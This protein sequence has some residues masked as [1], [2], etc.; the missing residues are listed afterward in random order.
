[1]PILHSSLLIRKS[2]WK[3][4]A[5]LSNLGVGL[6]VRVDDTSKSSFQCQE[7]IW[8]DLKKSMN[9]PQ[10]VDMSLMVMMTHV[11]HDLDKS[12]AIAL[13]TLTELATFFSKKRWLRI[14]NSSAKPSQIVWNIK[15]ILGRFSLGFSY[16][17]EFYKVRIVHFLVTL[18]SHTV[19][20]L[21]STDTFFFL[22]NNIVL[23]CMEANLSIGWYEAVRDNRMMRTIPLQKWHPPQTVRQ[24]WVKQ[25]TNFHSTIRIFEFTIAHT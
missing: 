21:I 1:M 13:G 18:I 3:E 6:E 17:M 23:R 8:S 12:L 14:G 25:I 15:V 9:F 19:P 11:I 22:H 7:L 16:G 20:W 2:D 10:I 5:V 24:A 4:R